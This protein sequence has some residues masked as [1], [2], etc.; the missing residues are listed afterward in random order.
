MTVSTSLIGLLP[1][2]FGT[3][4]GA[5]V[6]KRLAAP[7]VG[8]LFSAAALTLIV[9]PALNMIIHRARLRRELETTTTDHQP[10]AAAT[11]SSS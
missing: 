6:M 11:T 2:M 1:V 8:G 3:E 5:E 7:M 10:E 9:I 4:T